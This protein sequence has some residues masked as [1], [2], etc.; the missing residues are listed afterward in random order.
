ME[1]WEVV[2]DDW[3][4]EMNVGGSFCSIL[5][6]RVDD[7]IVQIY[8]GHLPPSFGGAQKNTQSQTLGVPKRQLP[9]KKTLFL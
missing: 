1:H 9:F 8:G 5:S 2:E 6:Y 7:L 4:V 3:I